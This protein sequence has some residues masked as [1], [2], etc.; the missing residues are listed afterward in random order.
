MTLAHDGGLVDNPFHVLELSPGSSSI[1]IERAGQRLLAMLGIGMESAATYPSPL[2]TR[3]RDAD[4]V[5]R[6]VDA[7][8]D[9]ERRRVAEIWALLPPG[10]RQEPGDPMLEPWPEALEAL[11][12]V[13]RS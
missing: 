11:G 1:E 9:P 8:R 3:P 13:R 12:W 5:R 7:L 4:L 6:S 2:G 10:P